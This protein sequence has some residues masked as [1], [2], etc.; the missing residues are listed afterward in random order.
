MLIVTVQ[1]REY[2]VGRRNGYDGN[3]DTFSSSSSS[4]PGHDTSNLAALGGG[5]TSGSGCRRGTG[6]EKI[7]GSSLTLRDAPL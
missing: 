7:T 2:C 6:E 1:G 4:Y 3:G 5:Q